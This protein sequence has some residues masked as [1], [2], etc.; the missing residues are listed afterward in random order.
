ME[1]PLIE[2]KDL[3][4]DFAGIQVLKGISLSF[5][6]GEV[7][8]LLG[9]NGAGKSTL[10]KILTG[11]Y[12][13][14]SGEILLDGKPIHVHRPVDAHAHGL[15]AVYQDSELAGSLTVA[16]NILLGN[17]PS[18]IWVN[19]R[20]IRQEAAR[21]MKEIGL[22]LD[23]DRKAS[24]L[25]A[26]QMQMVTLATLFHRRYKLIILDEPTA[27]L[28][29]SES[30]LLFK[31]IATFKQ[32]G[33]TI[34]YISHRL[35]E[36]KLLCDRA[37]ILRDGRV[38]GTLER[39]KI[40]EDVVTQLMVNRSSADLQIE[41]RGLRQQKVVLELKA[42]S[43]PRL[44]PLS[45]TVRAGEILG[46][47]GPLGAGME[48]IEKCL[49]G[50]SLYDGEIVIDG[51]V[52]IIRKPG[53]AL[54]AGIALIPEERRKQALFPS[55]SMA[56]N[57]SLPA[58]SKLTQF[59]LVHGVAKR[60]YAQG[61]IERLAIYPNAP[62]RPIRYFSGGNQQKAV[63]GKWL[64]RKAKV[65]VFVEP[66]SGVDVGAIRQIYEIILKMAEA[67][68][69]VIVISTSVKELLAL[70]E[71]IMVVHDGTVSANVPRSAVDRDGLLAMTI[72]KDAQPK[73]GMTISA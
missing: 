28:S 60:S 4:K 44:A 46:V 54:K 56:E 45:L 66:T 13:P 39:G 26:A 19:R 27:R 12:S 30:E 9:E 35:H 53:D 20:R 65:Y 11:V 71:T 63:I 58:L 40:D 48:Q 21:I 59:G 16:E 23:P 41:N 67:G 29:A 69:A 57:V 36:V 72:S 31:M 22:D 1:T 18:R 42:L 38:S 68:A 34:I 17:E 37:T 33:I 73:T 7:H 14:S 52:K 8:G 5:E 15:G 51:A 2:L 61:I 49:G 6:R 64:E 43:T 62:D 55:L 70:C 32:S 10:I 25:T 50:L 24:T 3:A 47:T